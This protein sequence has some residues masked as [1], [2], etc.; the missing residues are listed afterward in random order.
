MDCFGFGM[1][2]A[3]IDSLDG[4]LHLPEQ[5]ERWQTAQQL[6]RRFGIKCILV[7]G[8]HGA[9][10]QI[11]W[12]S[13]DI[14]ASWI[15]EYLAE[16]YVQVDP[17]VER[18]AVLPGSLEL[19]CGVARREDCAEVKAWTLNHK[20]KDA[21]FGGLHC[22]RFGEISGPGKFVTLGFEERCETAIAATPLDL[23]LFAALLAATINKDAPPPDQLFAP[24]RGC[25]LTT[26]QREVLSLL[27][28]G[29]LT[30]RIAERLGISEAAVTL[31]FSN[32]R[33]ALGAST[34]EHALA[35][36][37]SRGLISL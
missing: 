8:A 1:K 28:E 4:L 7:A 9:K 22:S 14:P 26:R 17:C 33:K 36:A 11:D 3:L 29:M 31:H 21:G 15:E 35:L 2:N 20:L 13:T 32:A 30:A 6:A 5:A 23:R 25:V 34:R 37:L 16:D 19:D 10:K 27:A 12:I 24:G 18:L